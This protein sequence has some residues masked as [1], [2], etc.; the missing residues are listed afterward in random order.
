M[1]KSVIFTAD[2]I[3]PQIDLLR[4]RYPS[5]DVVQSDTLTVQLHGT[6]PVHRS[7]SGFVVNKQYTI[8]IYIPLNSEKLPYVI[9]S[10]NCIS[11]YYRHRY[12][13]GMLCLET[14]ASIRI[15]FID[16][17]D[18]ATWIYD[19]VEV[20]YFSYEYFVRY[21]V[22]PFG[23]REHGFIGC[24]QAFQD[25]LSTDDLVTTYKLMKYVAAYPY[26]G[27]HNCPCGS[28][29][30]L[31]KCHGSA[32]MKFYHDNRLMV[33]LRQEVK[34]IDKE[35]TLLHEQRNNLKKAK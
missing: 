16:G 21:G 8:D 15:R 2:S 35:L 6:L 11:P 17:F 20:Y 1:E 4:E 3:Q 5:L 22:F 12:S 29:K 32:I 28:H 31:R 19:Y 30:H 13:N 23:D 9:D 7:H 18:L 25:L 26:R 34:Y 27:H 33:I 14:D 24:L 10:C